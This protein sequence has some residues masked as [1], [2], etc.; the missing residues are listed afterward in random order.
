MPPQLCV[1]FGIQ[2]IEVAMNELSRRGFFSVL[3]GFGG[4]VIIGCHFPNAAEGRPLVAP[5]ADTSPILKEH[6]CEAF[7]AMRK[8][9]R[10]NLPNR[11]MYDGLPHVLEFEEY[12]AGVLILSVPAAFLK[13]WIEV[14]HSDELLRAVAST[15]PFAERVELM[16]RV[17]S[18]AT[19]A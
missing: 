6:A 4:V 14:E 13:H 19:F 12:R 7:E 17:K 9:F 5:I 16:V 15:Y 8:A 1:M 11:D 10:R 2:H 3:C 18:D